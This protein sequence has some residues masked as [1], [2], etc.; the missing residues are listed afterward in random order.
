MLPDGSEVRG[1]CRG[2]RP[3]DPG[4]HDAGRA[5]PQVPVHAGA[6]RRVRARAGPHRRRPSGLPTK[7]SSSPSRSARSCSKTSR[8]VAPDVQIPI[9]RLDPEPSAP[10]CAARRRRGLRPL[11]ARRRTAQRRRRT[12]RRTR[13]ASRSRSRR[14]TRGSCSRARDSRC[15]TASPC[16]NTPGLID[17]GYR[18]EIRVLLVNT[19]P[20]DPVHG[21]ARRPHR[22]ARDPAGR[23]RRVAR[24]RHRSTTRIA[25]SAAG[26]RPVDPTERG[27]ARPWHCEPCPRPQVPLRVDRARHR[28]GA[29]SSPSSPARPKALGY[30]TLFVPDHFIDHQ[31]APT[32][33][34]A[35]AAAVTDDA[36]R[37]AARARQRLQA[38]G[39]ARA[40][41]RRRSTCSP[42]AGSS[43]ASA[44]A[45]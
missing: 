5:L 44:R 39:R 8:R 4:R 32:V 37:R 42:T 2:R 24:G 9:R 14:A 33:A 7:R 28:V 25:A 17:A 27:R 12:R 15:G 22:A 16:L 35:H 13:P 23:G 45:G 43:S 41:G 11:R 19:D 21:P 38:S 40:R 31:L 26:A 36:A 30:S 18:D 10:G 34:L 29:R 1:R 20:V 6:D 3:P